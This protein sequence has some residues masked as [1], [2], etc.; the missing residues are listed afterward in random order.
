MASRIL[1]ASVARRGLSSIHSPRI[2]PR[3]FTHATRHARRPLDSYRPALRVA[4]QR[5]AISSTA[6]RTFADVD[7][8]FDPRQQ[9]RESDEVDVCI[10]GG[11][12]AGLG[13]AI[14]LKQLANEAGNED[15]RVLLLEKSGELGD[16]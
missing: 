6:R 14:R 12:P 5:R 3:I 9:E 13:A 4:G 16:H 11:G 15:F 1:P 7:D 10:V 8:S 2:A